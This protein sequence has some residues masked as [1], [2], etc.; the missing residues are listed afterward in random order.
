MKTSLKLATL[1]FVVALAA[2]W[3]GHAIAQ[4]PTPA[5]EESLVAPPAPPS[6]ATIMEQ[7]PTIIQSQPMPASPTCCPIEVVRDHTKLSAR[8]MYRC[9]GPGVPQTLC[10]DN[11]A[12]CTNCLYAVDV[13]VPAC[14]TGA[15]VCCGTDVGLLGRGYV[16][17][18]WPCG[19]EVKIAFR[20]HGGVIL[21]YR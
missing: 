7:A 15:P 20:V 2:S 4:E 18:Q 16:T 17:Y 19:F 14:C 10:V 5:T 6:E 11:P 1:M 8:R 13:C 9:Y 12:D 21:T 3:N